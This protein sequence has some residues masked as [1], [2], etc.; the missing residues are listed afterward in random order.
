[1]P[2]DARLGMVI[3]VTVVIAFAILFFR[4]DVPAVAG[5]VQNPGALRSPVPPVPGLPSVIP[6][7]RKHTVEEGETLVS[8]A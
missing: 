2:K 6:A 5:N 3:G 7:N 4:K 8:I 1:M